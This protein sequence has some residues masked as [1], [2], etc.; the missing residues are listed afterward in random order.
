MQ[1][2]AH[3]VLLSGPSGGGKSTFA[4]FL[5]DG[6]LPEDMQRRIA[7]RGGEWPVIDVTNTMRRQIE[8]QGPA[9]T[10]TEMG[11][12]SQFI[13]HYDITT[14][15]RYGL[16]GYAS[17]PALRLLDLARSLQIV[18]VC[19]DA[20]RLLT[21][22]ADRDAVRRARKPGVARAWNSVVLGSVRGL[23]ARLAGQVLTPERALY[24]DPKWMEHCYDAWEEYISGLMATGG[25]QDLLRV[26]PCR[27]VDE[28]P[29]F[30]MV[31]QPKSLDRDSLDRAVGD[32]T[33]D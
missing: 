25:A 29:T 2:F 3:I 22:F 13:L 31:A 24:S 15:Y 28:E 33:H 23:R 20:R 7:P 11:A 26:E 4:R 18:F 27:D 16:P 17:D 1:N 6:Q 8:A 12:P 19:P 9:R 32:G 30:R 10:A 14:V 5:R 21:Q